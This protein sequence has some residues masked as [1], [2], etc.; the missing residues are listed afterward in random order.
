MSIN[1]IKEEQ[2]LI[3]AFNGNLDNMKCLTLQENI[4][5]YIKGAKKV[6]FDLL[7]VEK[8]SQMFFHLCNLVINHVK[9]ENF[10]II[11]INLELVKNYNV[12]KFLN[13]N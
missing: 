4:L 9:K 1:I 5:E 8:I 13:C 6:I 11:N 3:I 10:N 2:G 7:G 12:N